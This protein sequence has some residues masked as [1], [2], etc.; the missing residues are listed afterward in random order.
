MTMRFLALAALA[1]MTL[2]GCASFGD[3]S[4]SAPP[5]V[6]TAAPPPVAEPPAPATAAAV[7]A[8]EP[9]QRPD[10]RP[11]LRPDP[12]PQ[13][14]AGAPPASAAL[15]PLPP[16]YLAA[17]LSGLDLAAVRARLGEPQEVRDLAPAQEWLYRDDGC[18]LTVRFFPAGASLQ[19][20]A[21]SVNVRRDA[22]DDGAQDNHH[23]P[24]FRHF[25]ERLRPTS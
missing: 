2:A 20:K 15:E 21:L 25:A 9:R 7:P 16:G 5:E 12:V 6:T 4:R 14:A 24:C 11:D 17:Q 3:S 8:P 18:V 1:G 23:D 10:L 22:A 13:P 19:Y